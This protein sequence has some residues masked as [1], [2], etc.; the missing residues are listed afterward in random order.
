MKG[1]TWDDPSD[2]KQKDQLGTH[3]NKGINFEFTQTKTI[4]STWGLLDKKWN[5]QLKM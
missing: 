3:I 5:D 4:G 1:S 2:K